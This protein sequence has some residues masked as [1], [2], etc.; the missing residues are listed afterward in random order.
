MTW[1]IERSISVKVV[2][3]VHLNMSADPSTHI[4]VMSSRTVDSAETKSPTTGTSRGVIPR[5]IGWGCAARFPKPLTY[6]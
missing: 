6:L 2:K 4:L 3:A 1:V 5:K